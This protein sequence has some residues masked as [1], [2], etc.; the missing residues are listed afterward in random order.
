MSKETG[1]ETHIATQRGYAVDPTTAAGVLVEPGEFVPAGIAVSEEW[2]KPVKKAERAALGA[3]AEALDPHPK[4]VDLTKLNVTA[5][6]AMAAE[7]GINVEQ[8]GKTLTKNELIDAIKAKRE[9]DA[10]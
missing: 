9:H 2:M 6:Q 10:G 5:L 1:S 8:D 3:Q 4:D 7:R